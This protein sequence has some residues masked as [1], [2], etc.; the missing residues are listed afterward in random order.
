MF[1]I[2]YLRILITD[3]LVG[4]TKFV[5]KLLTSPE[6]SYRPKYFKQYI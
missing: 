6:E 1:I 3:Y 4:T 2:I 5:W